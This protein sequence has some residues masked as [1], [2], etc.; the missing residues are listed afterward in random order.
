MPGAFGTKCEFQTR[1]VFCVSRLT[2]SGILS[3][4]ISQ[5]AIRSGFILANHVAMRSKLV[6]PSVPCPNWTFQ[7]RTLSGVENAELALKKTNRT[8]HRGTNRLNIIDTLLPT[9]HFSGMCD[10]TL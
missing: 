6:I 4:G 7:L 8:T 1:P 10:L 3:G 2:S 9:A 5:S